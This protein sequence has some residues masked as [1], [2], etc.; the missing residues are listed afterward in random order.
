MYVNKHFRLSDCSGATRGG[1]LDPARCRRTHGLPHD[2]TF[3]KDRK[4]WLLGFQ[5]TLSN[6]HLIFFLKSLVI[7]MALNDYQVKTDLQAVPIRS[8]SIEANPIGGYRSTE[9][10]LDDLPRGS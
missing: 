9:S 10:G 1:I 5:Y 2:G 3:T 6:C 7:F 8:I 4:K